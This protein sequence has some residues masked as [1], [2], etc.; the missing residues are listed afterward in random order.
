VPDGVKADEKNYSPWVDP[1]GGSAGYFSTGW[2]MLTDST[3]KYY[4]QVGWLEY[5][6][7]NRIIFTEVGGPTNFYRTPY[8]P[9]PI[10]STSTVEVSWDPGTLQRFK[11]YVNGSIIGGENRLAGFTPGEAQISGETYSTATQMA[12]GYSGT[13]YQSWENERVWYPSTPGGNWHYFNENWNTAFDFTKS[14]LFGQSNYPSP[15]LDSQYIW[16]TACPN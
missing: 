4:A 6:G 12:G 7:S 15:Y 16:D 1:N 3:V 8:S 9:Q 10:N 13:H 5:S 14:A 2:V 11:F